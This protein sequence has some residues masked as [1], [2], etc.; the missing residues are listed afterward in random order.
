[1]AVQRAGNVGIYTISV[2]SAAN[3]LSQLVATLTTVGWT[4][5]TIAAGFKLASPLTP[6]NLRMLVYLENIGETGSGYEQIRIRIGSVNGSI[7]SN[8]LASAGAMLRVNTTGTTYRI[9]ASKF[10][11]FISTLGGYVQTYAVAWGIP[12]VWDDN[13]PKVITNITPGSPGVVESAGHGFENGT[14]IFQADIPSGITGASGIF[15]VA[16]KTT[17]T[18][19][20]QGSTVAGTYSSGGVVAD[21]SKQFSEI[22]WL[23]SSNGASWMWLF[24]TIN[25]QVGAVCWYTVN[26]NSVPA[27]GMAIT[28]DIGS[29]QLSMF[30]PAGHSASNNCLTFHNKHR[31]YTPE[32]CFSTSSSVQSKPAVQLWDSCLFSSSLTRDLSDLIDGHNALAWSDIT[33]AGQTKSTLMLFTD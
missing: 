27:S 3:L 20:L 5:T 22:M 2:N 25:A 33:G 23:S 19:E 12:Y 32:V 21:I 24:N 7:V 1:M 16:N 26:G 31:A 29:P 17:N 4:S 28:A 15:T 30:I 11:V 10:Q 9:I 8:S 6:T 13:K 14:T 18:Y